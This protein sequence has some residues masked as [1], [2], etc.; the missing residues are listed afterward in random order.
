MGLLASATFPE[1]NALRET[2][3][4]IAAA[5]VEAAAMQFTAQMAQSFESI[6]LGRVFLVLPFAR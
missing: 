4:F 3:G 2:M 5:N 6:V 1:I